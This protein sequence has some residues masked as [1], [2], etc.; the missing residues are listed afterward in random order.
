MD[1]SQMATPLVS[2]AGAII[3]CLINN[4]VQMR[5]R[6]IEQD[7]H[8]EEIK[9]EFSKQITSVKTELREQIFEL[10]AAYQQSQA[11]IACQIAELDKKQEVHNKVIER[12]YKCEGDIKRLEERT[13]KGA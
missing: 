11:V 1:L 12:V 8:I 9:N 10:S 7:K 5:K 6:D 2:A 3:V 13:K 4:F